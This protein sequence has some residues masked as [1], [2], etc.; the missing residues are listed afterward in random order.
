MTD[1][2]LVFKPEYLDFD[3]MISGDGDLLGDEG[4]N[5][6]MIVS[7]FTDRLAKTGDR[8]PDA[9]PGKPGDPR[10][11]WGNEVET[12]ADPD[13]IGSR[14]WLLNRE[15][16]L[17]E[18]IRRA[19]QYAAEAAEW[20]KRDRLVDE[21]LTDA[22]RAAEGWLEIV[23]ECRNPRFDSGRTVKWTMFVNYNS[24]VVRFNI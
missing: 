19:K 20:L 7:L 23:V 22:R 11:W 4:L 3:M 5:T 12:N 15:K 17:D 6:P 13:E 16:Q 24:G 10:G 21:V 9:L 18:T 14:L 2:A 8:I 1:I